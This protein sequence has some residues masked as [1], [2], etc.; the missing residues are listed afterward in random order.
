VYA[1]VRKSVFLQASAWLCL[2][3][4]ILTSK[5]YD[6]AAQDGMAIVAFDKSRQT[7]KRLKKTGGQ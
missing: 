7:D 4:V 2:G 6:A 5:H 1:P 3:R